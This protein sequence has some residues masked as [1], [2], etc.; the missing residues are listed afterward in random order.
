MQ[1][2][3][4]TAE[5]QR[6]TA[7]VSDSPSISHFVKARIESMHESNAHRD[8]VAVLGGST[9]GNSNSWPFHHSGQRTENEEL[10]SKRIAFIWILDCP[11]RRIGFAEAFLIAP[12]GEQ[13]SA[14][15][16]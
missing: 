7:L 9:L 12:G 16:S 2:T 10:Y 3:Q 14:S 11:R 15:G 13:E 6:K 8:S 5:A 1:E 4:E